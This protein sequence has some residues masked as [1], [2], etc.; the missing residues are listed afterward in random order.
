MFCGIRDRIG[1]GDAGA[2]EAER[3]GLAGERDLR[4][5]LRR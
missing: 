3:A 1:I 2:I 5:I 4:C